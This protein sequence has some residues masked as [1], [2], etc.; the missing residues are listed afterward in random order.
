M[1]LVDNN[2]NTI[3]CRHKWVFCASLTY[4]ISD[5]FEGVLCDN[6]GMKWNDIPRPVASVFTIS[7]HIYDEQEG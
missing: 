2:N 5:M 4:P 7:Q 1:L 3:V 6:C